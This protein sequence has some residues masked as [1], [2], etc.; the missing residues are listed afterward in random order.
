MTII[1]NL[2]ILSLVLAGAAFL[3]APYIDRYAVGGSSKVLQLKAPVR[4]VRDNNGIPYIY[5]ETLND[6]IRGQGFATAQDRLFQ[7]ELYRRI[8]WG[9]LSELIG[10]DGLAMDKQVHLWNLCGL[11]G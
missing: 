10:G 7:M 5:A 3:Y 4:I 2:I 1:R 9:R 6:A 8:A 11:Y